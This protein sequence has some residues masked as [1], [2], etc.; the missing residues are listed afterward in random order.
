[1]Y[2]IAAT[3]R[4]VAAGLLLT[5][6]GDLRA[7]CEPSASSQ[8]SCEV[9]RPLQLC[10][11][12][13]R[14]APALTS[15]ASACS[16]ILSAWSRLASAPRHMQGAVSTPALLLF[17]HSPAPPPPRSTSVTAEQC[18]KERPGAPRQSGAG[19]ALTRLLYGRRYLWCVV[20]VE[21]RLRILHGPRLR[22]G[23]WHAAAGPLSTGRTKHVV[24]PIG[25]RSSPKETISR[26]D[27]GPRLT[28]SELK[29]RGHCWQARGGDLRGGRGDRRRPAGRKAS[30]S[31]CS[32]THLPAPCDGEPGAVLLTGEA[33]GKIVAVT[34]GFL[35]PLSGSAPAAMLQPGTYVHPPI[36][37]RGC[38]CSLLLYSRQLCIAPARG[39][40][41]RQRRMRT[42]L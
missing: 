5:H 13:R 42:S 3:H 36:S 24:S 26:P 30:I 8:A 12:P 31:T 40:R 27:R 17:S 7:A 18:T 22:V 2:L 16:L 15:C 11:M 29:F 19:G 25:G 4:L 34:R 6:R 38:G 20:P 1:M 21:R 14:P 23:G 9:H 37:R 32:S 35:L 33:G 39:V 28:Q 41:V 10:Q